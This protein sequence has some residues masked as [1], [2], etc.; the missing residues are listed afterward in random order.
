MHFEALL[1][2]D[3]LI[4]S[5]DAVCDH[6]RGSASSGGAGGGI[7]SVVEDHAGVEAGFG[8]DGLAADEVEELSGGVREVFE[9]RGGH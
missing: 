6:P 3:L 5:G 2:H 7:F 4:A 8:I 1:D 9:E